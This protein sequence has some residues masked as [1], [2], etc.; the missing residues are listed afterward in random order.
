MALG[1]LLFFLTGGEPD[2]PQVAKAPEKRQVAAKPEQPV[3]V[4]LPDEKEAKETKLAAP[5]KP[6]EPK[7]A[8]V[9]KKPAARAKKRASTKK[10]APAKTAKAAAPKQK[11]I[12]APSGKMGF[13]TVASNPKG[14]EVFV[15]DE[16]IGL[17]PVNNLKFRQGEHN[18]KVVKK[19]FQTYMETINLLDKNRYSVSLVKGKTDEKIE[20]KAAPGATAGALDVFVPPKSVIYIDGKEYKEEKVSLQNLSP[21]SHMVYI[22]MKGRKP[23]N[24]RIT[25]T[26]GETK[27]IDVR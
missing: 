22:Q 25:I 9:A 14:A 5:G 18:L 8:A 16:F 24:K 13:L 20:E 26:Q 2:K 11:K 4:V 15:G 23:Y 7:K 10:K 6:A 27:T 3:N 1:L 19:G 21:G 12:K 17:T